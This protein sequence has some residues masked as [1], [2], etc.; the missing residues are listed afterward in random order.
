MSLPGGGNGRSSWLPLMAFFTGRGNGGGKWMK[1]SSIT[2]DSKRSCGVS[3]RLQFRVRAGWGRNGCRRVGVEVARRGA[4]TARGAG[5][6][7]RWRRGMMRKG[8]WVLT[9][10][11]ARGSRVGA[12]ETGLACAQHHAGRRRGLGGRSA[13]GQGS[14]APARAVGGSLDVRASGRSRVRSAGLGRALGRVRESKER[15]ERTGEREDRGRE[16]ARRR[17]LE[18]SW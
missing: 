1:S 3:L 14:V 15:R 2:R 7:A 12:L 4:W 10:S 13:S 5:R 9:A 6:R 11:G 18:I 8:V 17:R 16:R